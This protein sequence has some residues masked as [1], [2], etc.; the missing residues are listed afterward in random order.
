MQFSN[1]HRAVHCT[2]SLTCVLALAPQ[3][4]EAAAIVRE[5]ERRADAAENAAAAQRAEREARHIPRSLWITGRQEA[6]WR[7]GGVSRPFV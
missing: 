6:I 7:T 2:P 5:Q 1:G 3:V 4:E